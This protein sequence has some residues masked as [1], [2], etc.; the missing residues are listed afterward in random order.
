MKILLLNDSHWG[1]RNSSEVFESHITQFHKKLLKYI[2]KND[3][4]KI[5]HL[6]DFFDRRKEI[7][8][9]TLD[10][11]RKEFLTPLLNLG[12]SMDVIVGNHDSHF[13]NTNELNSLDLL[14]ADYS[15][16]TVYRDPTEVEYNGL[17]VLMLPWINS[18]NYQ[19]SLTAIGNSKSSVCF[20][21]LELSGF[22]Y[23]QG[24]EATHG[25][26]RDLFNDF[27]LVLTGHYH[28]K[29]DDGR[30]FYLGTQYDLTWADYGEKKYYHILDTATLELEKIEYDDLL[31]KRLVYID[32][33]SDDIEKIIEAEDFKRCKGKIVKV[34]VKEKRNAVAFDLFMDKLSKAHPHEVTV[35]DDTRNVLINNA[36]TNILVNDHFTTIKHAV[37]NLNT[38][39]DKSRI[40]KLMNELYEESQ[41]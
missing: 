34:V 12:V 40:I 21:H 20:A 32:D 38:S 17:K 9:R 36:N 7:N 27:Q 29:S 13:K 26:S 28:S 37:E 39:L 6:G 30:I 2:K 10:V 35:V 15:N 41:I 16:V 22:I 24:M 4:Q 5:V 1:V 18:G 14:M 25:M 31:F 19:D 23:Q 33:G 11:V 8:F 3:I